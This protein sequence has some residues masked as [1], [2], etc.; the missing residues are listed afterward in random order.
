METPAQ[1]CARLVVALEDLVACEAAT[2]QNRDFS[3]ALDI[4][5]RAAPLIDYLAT[6]GSSYADSDLQKR[7]HALAERRRLT[8]ELLS[9]QLA[10]VK[11]SL[12]STRASQHRVARIAPVYGSAAV[13][14]SGQLLA[15]G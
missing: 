12:Q 11:E 14:I 8:G 2:V 13:P 5:E 4:Q 6:N 3:G 9:A 15:V 7:I 1:T 10:E